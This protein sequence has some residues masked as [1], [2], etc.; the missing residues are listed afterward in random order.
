MK[1][2]LKK[3]S[4]L[5]LK[6][7]RKVNDIFAG[8]YHAV[9]KGQGLEFD[10]VRLYQYGDEIRSIDWN[11]T[12]RTGEVFIKQFKEER[13]RT[14][15]VLFDVSGS[16]DFGNEKENKLMIG[17]EIASILAFSA[18]KNNDKIGMATFS[19]QIEQFYPPQKGRKHV[20]A[21]IRSLLTHTSQSKGTNLAFALDFIRKVQ[22][23]RSIVLIISDFLDTNYET[24]LRHLARKHEL[25]LI[26]L[27]NPN[28]VLAE[29]A[30]TMPVMDMETGNLV[31]IHAGDN[32][33]GRELSLQFDNI[34]RQ[35]NYLAQK[36]KIDYLSVNTHLDYFPVLEAFFKRRKGK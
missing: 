13:E 31:W 1:E 34:D 17:T 25:I 32:R 10:E 22:K 36:N 9:F 29:G 35:L 20:L 23:R 16:E 15:F 6:I 30:G 11:V 5:E 27:F 12:A 8:E 28:E 21:I 2:I 4:R 7:R 19:D 18:L 33:Y 24:Q 3:V 26:R 14:L